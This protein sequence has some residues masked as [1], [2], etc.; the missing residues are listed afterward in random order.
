[1]NTLD[2]LDAQTL[3]SDI[4]AFRPLDRR[5]T[6]EVYQHLFALERPPEEILV[7]GP[8][9]P[10][11]GFS[12]PARFVSVLESEA[13]F[14]AREAM[15]L[16]LDEHDLANASPARLKTLLFEA[17]LEVFSPRLLLRAFRKT[18]VSPIAEPLGTLH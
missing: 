14:I 1:M 15:L 11:Y 10:E 3:R 7:D 6:T 8:A 4:P 16:R 18:D 5:R 2:E 9:R 12:Q 13:A 17:S